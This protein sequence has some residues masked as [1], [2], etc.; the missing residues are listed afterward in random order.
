MLYDENGK[1]VES[2]NQ[3][4]SISNHDMEK[5]QAYLQGCV[6]TWCNIYEEPT[7]FCAADFVG[8][9]NKEWKGTPPYTLFSSRL[10]QYRREY[11]Q[12]SEKEINARAFDQAGI[13]LGWILKSVLI[14]DKRTFNTQKEFHSAYYTWDGKTDNDTLE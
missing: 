5:I 4:D 11:S 10:E 8:G 9:T 1:L 7:K 12:E 3:I 14:K 6:Y 2:A 13:D